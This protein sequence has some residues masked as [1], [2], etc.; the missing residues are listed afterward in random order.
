MK[1]FSEANTSG[2]RALHYC[3]T[4]IALL[5][6]LL[7]GEVEALDFTYTNNTGAI[8]IT[9]YTGPGGAV[10][11]PSRINGLQ[12]T[13]IG[14]EAFWLGT[15]LTSITIADS[16]TNI[17]NFAFG[18]C[19]SLAHVTIGNGV[20]TI[21]LGAF[22]ACWRLTSVTIPDSV[23]NL[24]DGYYTVGGGGAFYGCTS[25]TNVTIGNSVT[26]IG[27]SAFW[28][29]SS[30]TNITIP[31][32]VLRIGAHAFESCAGLKG[33]Y[34]QGNAPSAGPPD[35]SVFANDNKPTVYYLPG[36]SGWGST[37]AV[38]PAVL[39]NPHP[40]TNDG[41][42][43]V[44]QN[45]FGFNIAGTP[46]IPIVVEA[47]TNLAAQSWIPLQSGTLTNGLIYFGDAEWTNFPS[48]LYRLRSP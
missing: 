28:F 41:N 37:F 1:F 10:S 29:C 31:K 9:G 34:F 14:D 17:G 11:I 48:R 47:T 21:C 24:K 33:V 38:V 7:T 4:A 25:L 42:F 15:N 6:L 2:L 40:Q 12:V 16:V 20:T 22:N 19:S 32:S 44:R 8:T 3:I 45:R 18:N 46:D 30:L 5:L 13:S 26:N 36:T 39:W 23:T 43:G 35:D 27:D